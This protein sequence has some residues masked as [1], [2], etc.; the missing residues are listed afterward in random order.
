MLKIEEIEP[1]RV[2]P[3]HCPKCKSKLAGVG[4]LPDS[5]IRG[6]SFH[7]KRCSRT[8]GVTATAKTE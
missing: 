4:L 6:L 8:L 5:E 1:T 2:T 3:I 7:C